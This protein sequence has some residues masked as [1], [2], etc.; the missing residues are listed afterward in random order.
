L[1]DRALGQVNGNTSDTD[2]LMK[3]LKHTPFP[4]APVPVVF[5]ERDGQ[6]EIAVIETYKSVSQFWTSNACQ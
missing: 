4:S 1:L 5:E 6:L 2:A 3:A